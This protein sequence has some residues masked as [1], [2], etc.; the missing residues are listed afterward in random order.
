MSLRKMRLVLLLER[1]LRITILY[2]I[3]IIFRIWDILK[4]M[5]VKMFF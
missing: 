4:K 5:I 1:V 3:N 2:I